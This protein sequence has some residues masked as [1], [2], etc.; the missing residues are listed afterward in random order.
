[1]VKIIKNCKILFLAGLNTVYVFVKDPPTLHGYVRKK[2]D[3]TQHQC[4]NEVSEG[5]K[6]NEVAAWTSPNNGM[7]VI[8][9][10]VVPVKL[11]HGDSGEILKAC[12]LLSSCSQFTFILEILLKRFCIKGRRTSITIKTLNGEVNNKSSVIGG[13]KVASSRNSS[14]DRLE[15]S[16]TY[17]KKYW[18]LGRKNVATLSKLKQWVYLERTLDNINEDDNIYVGLLIGANCMKTMEPIDAILS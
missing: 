3:N 8:S 6:D 13:L 18:T 5:R 15:L 1:M 17:T 12:A 14:E 7:E 9:M 10:C 2:V 11:R 4:N 16:D